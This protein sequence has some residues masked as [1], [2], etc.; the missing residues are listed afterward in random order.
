MTCGAKKYNPMIFA[1]AI[2]K[3]IESDM[4][5]TAFKLTEA[6]NAVHIKKRPYTVNLILSIHPQN[7]PKQ[8]SHNMPMNHG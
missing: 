2:E 6:P 7:I 5:I 8:S 1:V 4:V 3:N